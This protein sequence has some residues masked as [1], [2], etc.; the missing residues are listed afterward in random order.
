MRQVRT[1][2]LVIVGL[3]ILFG[4]GLF[5]AVPIAGAAAAH[6]VFV[7]TNDPSAN[8]IRVYDRA[9]NGKLSFAASYATGGLRDS[10]IGAPTDA[11]SSQG[12]LT[13]DA[14]DSLLFAVNAGSDTVTVFAVSGDQLRR[15]QVVASGGDFPVSVTAKHGLVYAL[16]GGGD[17]SV[18]GYRVNGDQLVPISGSIRSLGL[19]NTTPPNFLSSPGQV[20]LSPSGGQLIIP[21]KSNG[22]IDVFNI[23]PTSRPS[24][25]PIQNPSAGAVPFTASFGASGHLIVTEAGGVAEGEGSVSSY[26]LNPNGTLTT[27]SAAVANGQDGTCWD[28]FSR[29]FLYAVNTGS[30]TIR[31]YVDAQGPLSLL[32]PSGVT[33]PTNAGPIDVASA[34]RFLYVEESLTGTLGEFGVAS[35]GSLTRIGTI[36]GL[37]VFSNGNGME[38]IA[39]T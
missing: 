23:N 32:D 29:G 37:P 31:G 28:A 25:T 11:L 21:T 34:G 33:A 26:V 13:F 7:Q 2:I 20:T 6:A 8:A 12:S 17:G 30:S 16:N 18:S 19:N 9:S 38:G 24:D 10:T 15:T 39:A 3:T 35:D 22:V 4:S 27:V 14:A 5:G 36:T 1:L